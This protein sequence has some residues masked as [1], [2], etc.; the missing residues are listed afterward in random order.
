MTVTRKK[1]D[2]VTPE[3][4]IEELVRKLAETES[5][6][7]A[8]LTEQT[9]QID[10]I[11][12]PTSV[13]PD[14]M[15]ETQKTLR[16]SE[17]RFRRLVIRISAMV[18]EL[19]R[20]G[21]TQFV[22]QTVS[23]L[24]GYTPDELLGK[25]WWSIFFPG[26][27][28]NKVENL[29]SR[30]QNGD[31][32]Q[33][34]LEFT[35]KDGSMIIVEL[36]TAN[37]YGP[38]GQLLT[39]TGFGIDC[40]RLLNQLDTERIRWQE[41]VESMPDQVVVCD[42]E[43]RVI[44]MNAANYAV[45]SRLNRPLQPDLNVDDHPAY[46]QLYRSDGTPFPAD[47]F[48]L[49]QALSQNKEVRNI[50]IVQYSPD[51]KTHIALWNAAPLHDTEGRVT[52]AVAI[53]H[54]ITELRRA[55]EE[56]VWLASFPELNPN[57][58]VE[59]D[60]DGHVRYLNSAAKR[61]LPDLQNAGPN[62]PW[63]ASLDE[64]AKR[65][66]NGDFI[67]TIREVKIGEH[68][69]QQTLHYVSES[70]SIRIYGLDITERVVA[71]EALHKAHAELE[72]RVAE[73]TRDLAITNEALQ[74]E[75]EERRQAEKQLHLQTTA[76]EAAANGI[77]ITDR[78]G[79]ILWSNPAL[80]NLSGYTADELRGQNPRLFHSG[81]HDQAYYQTMWETILPGQVW[82]G[83]TINRRKDG[84]LYTQ[85]QIITPV[86]DESG[87]IAYFISI[88]QDITARKQA[89]QE[90]FNAREL[91]E[92]SFSSSVDI[93]VAIM[94][95]DF[96]FLRVNRAYAEADEREPEFFLG[97]NHFDLYPN[98]ENQAIFRKV[99]ETG[100]PYSVFGKPFVY[101]GHPERGVTYWDWSLQ[102]LKEA[103][104]KVQGVVLNLVNVTGRKRAE[105]RI[106]EDAARSRILATVS[107]VLS[108][109]G[110]DYQ[111]VLDNFV[112]ATA[113]LIGDHC[114]IR[115]LSDDGKWL[116]PAAFYNPDPERYALQQKL[117]P[118]NPQHVD[119]GL[120]GRVFQTGQP[121]LIPE[122][123][124]EQYRL[125]SK[126]E[127]LPLTERTG[128]ASVLIVPLRQQTG[129]IGTLALFRNSP[130]HSYTL[131]D[132]T[133]MQNLA[134]RVTLAI[135]NARLYRDLEK[136]L[137]Q[138]Q[139]TRDQLIQSEKFAAM[140]RMVASVAHELNNP[141]Q[142]IK[143]CLYLIQ[144]EI[145]SDVPTHE[146]LDMATSEIRRLS[147]LVA[148]LR[149]IYRPRTGGTKQPQD[150]LFILETVH[151][152]LLPHLQ[153]NKVKYQ[154]QLPVVPILVDC[155]ADQIK[156]VFLNIS[157]NAIEAMHSEGGQLSVDMDTETLPGMTGVVFR[158]TGPGI[159][160]EN[161][162]N[163]FEPFF[164]YKSSGLGL[165]LPICYEIVV[166]HGGRIEVESQLGQGAAFTIWLPSVPK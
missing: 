150:L 2:L 165:G 68:Y 20:D 48:P 160:S 146:Y 127:F 112:R 82:H 119:E 148:Q 27:Q 64:V 9:G 154:Q 78:Q 122:V 59:M 88:Q 75:I 96:N 111:A 141:L 7:Q 65:F 13:E 70:Q 54:E 71:A 124:I 126:P 135:S 14:L 163:L 104:G 121:L 72:Q 26:E 62:H 56:L 125:I 161:L 15:R 140:G 93:L 130:G 23:S 29:I 90:L 61:L 117:L 4:Q 120:T 155:I 30:L 113:S 87:K 76:L 36:D 89:E 162:H 84:N 17:A 32:T 80:S 52:S 25:N 144:L 107:Q 149:E 115:L 116:N 1:K 58:V 45:A 158:D 108:E 94:D 19:T 73:R 43:G 91:L 145:A 106:R 77:F 34:E 18:F 46:Y 153:N 21:T 136:A 85:D 35:I 67:T 147:N 81:L 42:A 166:R 8:L 110:T 109:A 142:T 33:Y 44:Y 132:Q 40:T 159:P 157:M 129:L 69:Y 101:A 60:L 24:T 95:R 57:P 83:E 79:S 138:E 47:D 97:K 99:V 74:L 134:D 16:E 131:E 50:E 31:V 103:D 152:M 12:A 128:I 143:N 105:D 3:G 51:R 118:A 133:L 156:Q 123:S 55:E 86:L 11:L 49:R 63:N 5:A 28:R 92:K 37:Q 164:T 10:A 41:T 98:E 100:E 66:L 137:A 22:N 151:S 6:L 38:E 139:A 102:P 114:V 53:G 39:I